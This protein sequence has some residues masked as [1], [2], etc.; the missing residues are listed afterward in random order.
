VLLLRRH[1]LRVG[2]RKRWPYLV[3]VKERHLN[4]AL[5]NGSTSRSPNMALLSAADN[6][7]SSA[8]LSPAEAQGA[9]ESGSYVATT[10]RER[11]ESLPEALAMPV[12]DAE[13]AT[14]PSVEP[15]HV[16]SGRNI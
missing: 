13:S 7:S 4:A 9:Q 11:Q 15:L 6:Y 5:R 10:V 2:V 14:L 16:G 1:G 8:V 3:L 12:S